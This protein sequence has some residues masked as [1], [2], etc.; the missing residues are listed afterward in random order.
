MMRVG[1]IGI[2]IQ[3]AEGVPEAILL[4]AAAQNGRRSILP[5]LRLRDLLAD[6]EKGEKEV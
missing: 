3:E 4:A 1:L 5:S 2:L 6:M